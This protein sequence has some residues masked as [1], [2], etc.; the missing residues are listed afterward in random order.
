MKPSLQCNARPGLAASVLLL[1]LATGACSGGGGSSAN[2]VASTGQDLQVLVDTS[3]ASGATLDAQVDVIVLERVDGTFTSNLL[4]APQLLRLADPSGRPATLQLVNAPIGSYQAA[5]ILFHGDGG[6][7][8]T[9]DGKSWS[10]HCEPMDDRVLF[11]EVHRHEL[12]DHRFLALRHHGRIEVVEDG[13]GGRRW[14]PDF[15]GRSGAAE[16]FGPVELRVR[17]IDAANSQFAAELHAHGGEVAVTVSVP[18]SASLYGTTKTLIDRATF[19]AQL[20]VGAEVKATGTL[21]TGM[22]FRVAVARL[23]DGPISGGGG[24]GGTTGQWP[25]SE[26]SVGEVKGS[27]GELVIVPR[28]NDPLIVAGKSVQSQL[29][30]LGTGTRLFLADHPE[31]ALTLGE[32][33]AGRRIWVRGTLG[34][35]GALNANWV[36]VRP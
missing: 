18:E 26:G 34:G 3:T 5:R 15:S 31:R 19:F 33:Q 7:L 17:K 28:G 4:A 32:V 9:S 24:N 21:E 36:R 29:V 11:D 12:G 13:S 1:V 20:L 25:E 35:D 23:D 14:R 27:A 8:R 2:T 6:T 10:L 22:V 30:R 16:A